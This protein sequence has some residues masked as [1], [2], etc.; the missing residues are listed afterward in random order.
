MQVK[1][2][3]VCVCVFVVIMNYKNNNSVDNYSKVLFTIK[4]SLIHNINIKVCGDGVH[5]NLFR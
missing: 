1:C 5:K 2:V 4:Y 3:C